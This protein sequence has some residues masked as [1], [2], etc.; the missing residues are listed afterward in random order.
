VRI[1]IGVTCLTPGRTIPGG[2]L[3]IIYEAADFWIM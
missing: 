3:I 2:V 1:T